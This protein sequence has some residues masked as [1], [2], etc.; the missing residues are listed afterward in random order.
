MCLTMVKSAS[1]L[2]FTMTLITLMC[3]ATI[4]TSKIS[5]NL[6]VCD[7][8]KTTD[9]DCEFGEFVDCQWEFNGSPIDIQY[10]YKHGNEFNT[11]SCLIE[12][13][14][15]QSSIKY[16]LQCYGL[17]G[18]PGNE[19]D[20]T[21]NKL[22]LMCPSYVV[23]NC[24]WRRN[25]EVVDIDYINY[26]DDN[27]CSITILK[28]RKLDNGIWE[29][30]EIINGISTGKTYIYYEI[31]PEGLT[32]R[33]KPLTTS[34]SSTSKNK[35][36]AFQ[37]VECFR[38]DGIDSKE[39]VNDTCQTRL[40]SKTPTIRLT[41]NG[42]ERISICEFEAP[43]NCLWQYKG[44]V[45]YIFPDEYLH[46]NGFDT[47]N[48]SIK[49][50]KSEQVMDYCSGVTQ[51]K[52]AIVSEKPIKLNCSTTEK[53]Q[54]SWRK[55]GQYV[56][57][58]F[59]YIYNK[60][61]CSLTINDPTVD[62]EG[63]WEC[64]LHPNNIIRAYKLQ[65]LY[66][67]DQSRDDR[68][69]GLVTIRNYQTYVEYEC[70]FNVQV[71][72]E[73]ELGGLPLMMPYR[74][75]NLDKFKNYDCTIESSQLNYDSECYGIIQEP[76]S[77]PLS[78]KPI[79]LDCPPYVTAN[80]GW[81]RNGLVISINNIFYKLSTDENDN[82]LDCSIT[83]SKPKVIDYGQWECID[84]ISMKTF[85]YYYIEPSCD[86]KVGVQV[87]TMNERSSIVAN[88]S[89]INTEFKKDHENSSFSVLYYIAIGVI[90]YVA[91]CIVVL[92]GIWFKQCRCQ[93]IRCPTR[94][95]RNGPPLSKKEQF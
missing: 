61:D 43:V 6:K 33:I 13:S 53:I 42:W 5:A 85:R 49:L 76:L 91:L 17:I 2:P 19:I 55:D 29:C 82:I 89:S 47:K 59:R 60:H 30:V 65:M 15:L 24:G 4:Q 69:Q 8:D 10:K 52:T 78:D 84:K 92:Y 62:D 73:W 56:V 21:I 20:S 40:L 23:N 90:S 66:K 37:V 70:K 68:I 63:V 35:K 9:Y 45:I 72:C 93:R 36:T 81:R 95:C 54:C 57:S 51:I 46:G 12:T 64:V 38:S 80:C 16:N 50:N 77:K 39:T 18:Q 67:N 34:I 74:Y 41:E 11:Q 88:D 22:K 28:P 86:E 31:M 94:T 75:T 48:C 14:H 7:N 1:A 25:G 83:I 58:N 27:D 44:T 87:I 79:Q 32:W 26:S 71:Q 3:Q